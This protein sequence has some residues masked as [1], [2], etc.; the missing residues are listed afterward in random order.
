MIAVS[1]ANLARYGIE[2]AT[3]GKALQK[4]PRVNAYCIFLASLQVCM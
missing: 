3:L 2:P 1:D 4:D